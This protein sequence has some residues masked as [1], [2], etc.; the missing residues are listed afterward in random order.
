MY[1]PEA[2]RRAEKLSRRRARLWPVL[3]L[4]LISL[5]GWL[6]GADGAGSPDRHFS[7]P[8]LLSA[9]LILV[10][11]ASG[12]FLLRGR[13][14]RAMVE[15]ELAAAHR[16]TAYGV[17]FWVAVASCTL[18]YVGA[19]IEPLAAPAAIRLVL[20]LTLGSAMIA[21]GILQ[22]RALGRAGDAPGQI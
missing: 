13:S 1:D 6:P 21:F 17:G 2:T 18:I 9:M 7:M 15:D 10:A 22:G 5:Q 4:M 20:A 8:W 16:R 14:V 11:L 19:Q 3:G 12:G